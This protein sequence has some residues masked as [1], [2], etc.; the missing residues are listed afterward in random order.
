MARPDVG[1]SPMQAMGQALAGGNQN[2]PGV[3]T[4][5]GIAPPIQG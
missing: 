1:R 5:E 2:Q 3:N 4:R